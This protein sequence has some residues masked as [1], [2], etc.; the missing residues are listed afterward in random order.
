MGYAVWV[1]LISN[2][3]VFAKA[4]VGHP[5]ANNAPDAA[6]FLIKLRRLINHA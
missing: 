3:V 2:D 1:A 6:A 4:R 5:E